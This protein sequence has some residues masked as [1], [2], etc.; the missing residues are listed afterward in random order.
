MVES[1]VNAILRDWLRDHPIGRF[2][3]ETGYRLD[4]TGSLIPDLSVLDPD[5]VKRGIADL[6]HGAPDLAVEIVS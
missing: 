4:D 1:N 6:L 3:V 5:R 2:F